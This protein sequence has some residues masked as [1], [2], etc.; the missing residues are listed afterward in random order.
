MSEAGRDEL[1]SQFSDITGTTAD[2]ATFYLEA[3]NWT[4]QVIFFS[5]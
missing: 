5:S 2:R 1:I 4:L 3:A